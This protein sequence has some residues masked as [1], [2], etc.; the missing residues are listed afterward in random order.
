M[1]DDG[2]DVDQGGRID[3]LSIV[4]VEERPASELSDAI[5]TKLLDQQRQIRREDFELKQAEEDNTLRRRIEAERHAHALK[6][7]ERDHRRALELRDSNRQIGAAALAG[8]LALAVTGVCVFLLFDNDRPQLQQWAIGTLG[9]VLGAVVQSLWQYRP[10]GG[11]SKG[12]D[13]ARREAAKQ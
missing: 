2:D 1:S 11:R 9:I 3:D 8:V 7:E 5:R 10:E 13:E 6:A 12:E 4:R